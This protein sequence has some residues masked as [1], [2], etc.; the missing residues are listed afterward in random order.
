MGKTDVVTTFESETYV[1]P[2][3]SFTMETTDLV[4]IFEPDTR[5]VPSGSLPT[6]LPGGKTTF[7]SNPEAIPPNVTNSTDAQLLS[8][9]GEFC[10]AL[11]CRMLL[12]G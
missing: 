7:E 2:Y 5:E 3:D 12:A 1:V 9:K 6:E 4:T 11:S 8:K 10:L